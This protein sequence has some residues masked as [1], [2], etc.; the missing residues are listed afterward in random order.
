MQKSKNDLGTPQGL[1]MKTEREKLDLQALDALRGAED[2]QKRLAVEMSTGAPSI[3][4]IAYATKIRVKAA[5]N[6]VAKVLRKRTDKNDPGYD[7][8][9]LRDIVGLRI[10]TLFRLDALRV[11]SAVIARRA[12]IA[13]AGHDRARLLSLF[14]NPRHEQTAGF[15]LNWENPDTPLGAISRNDGPDNAV[16]SPASGRYRPLLPWLA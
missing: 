6:I 10:V 8:Y 1:G 13:S 16:Q 14:V 2:V 5:Y 7:V 11:I 12:A 4:D 9:R 15:T 3:N